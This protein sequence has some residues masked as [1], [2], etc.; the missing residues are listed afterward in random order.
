MKSEAIAKKHV[1]VLLNE[2]VNSVSID[3]TEQN[4]V[5]D[6][7]LGMAGHASSVIQKMNPGDIL[8]GFDADEKNLSLAQQRLEEQNI[9]DVTV[10]LIHANFSEL[11]QKLIEHNIPAIT[12][13]YYDLWLSSLHLDEA[14]RGFSFMLDGPLDMRLNKNIWK[15]AAEVVNGYTQAELRKI[16]LEYGEEPGANK[17]SALIVENRKKQKFKTTGSLA[18][19]I[20]WPP[21]VKARIFQALR[22]EVN[23]ELSA[24]QKSLQQAVSLL[25]S[26]GSISVISFHSLEDR[27]VKQYFKTESKDCICEDLI[28]SCHHTRTL[29]ILTKKPIIPSEQEIIENPRSRSA[30]ARVAKKI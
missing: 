18:E 21:K 26:G 20:P 3:T 24:I 4:I 13:I 28:C 25:S 2:I 10:I 16:F 1:S 17:I 7:T 23:N 19:I 27:V 30:K 14:E 5:V 6:A 22:I 9:H 8:I 12:A 29:K 11:Q 15:T